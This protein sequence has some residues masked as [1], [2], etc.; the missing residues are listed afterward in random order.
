MAARRAGTKGILMNGISQRLGAASGAYFVVAAVLG[1]LGDKGTVGTLVMFSGIAAL[2][3]FLGFLHATLDRA[4]AGAESLAGT[5]TASGL[6]FLALQGV[7]FGLIAVDHQGG[8]SG[9]LLP[10]L[11]AAVF[12]VSTVFFGLFVLAAARTLA[13]RVLPA[14]ASWAGTAAG[15]L[16]A[17]AG[18][19]GTVN[20]DAFIPLPY[21]AA[22]LWT[23]VVSALLTVRPRSAA[24]QAAARPV[25]VAGAV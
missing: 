13:R 1:S 2:L 20:V 12:V 17:V 14:W 16:A 22:L 21:M 18:A 9:Q 19:A 3:V 23:A 11:G 5:V 10:G 8:G 24:R 15:A 4:G 25:D 6:V 7:E